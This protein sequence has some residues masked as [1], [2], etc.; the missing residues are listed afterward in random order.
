MCDIQFFKKLFWGA[1]KLNLKFSKSVIRSK[2]ES[3]Q[4]KDWI[5]LKVMTNLENT[6]W[7]VKT[8]CTGAMRSETHHEVS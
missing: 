1:H 4:P 3:S 6:L 5:I 7:L 2:V 8:I